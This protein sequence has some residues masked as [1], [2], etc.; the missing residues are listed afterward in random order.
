M[1]EIQKTLDSSTLNR[2]KSLRQDNIF[3][4]YVPLVN[5]CM[6]GGCRM[7]LPSNNVERLKKEKTLE[8]DSCRRII[9]IK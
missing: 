7:E 6:C 1:L 5:D 2:Y 9:Y 4:V 8:C 3:P